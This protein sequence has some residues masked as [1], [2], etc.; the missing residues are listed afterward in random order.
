MKLEIGWTLDGDRKTGAP[1]DDGP[2]M[3][4]WW[5]RALR[6]L[7]TLLSWLNDRLGR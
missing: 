4:R 1:M 7:G 6:P 5:V 3:S 2:D